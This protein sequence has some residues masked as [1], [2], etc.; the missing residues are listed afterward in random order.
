VPG[1]GAWAGFLSTVVPLVVTPGASLT[2]LVQRVTAD[3]RR[4]AVAVI[5]GTVTALAVYG[6]VVL[7]GMAFLVA[8]SG[9][10]GAVLRPAGA[11]YLVGLGCWMWRS[12]TTRP[13]DDVA[14]P[15]PSSRRSGYAQALLGTV[16]NPK[17]A[18]IY[19]TVVPRFVDPAGSRST[20]L[21]ALTAA[22]A[23]LTASWLAAWTAVLGPARRLTASGPWRARTTRASAVVLVALGV[24]WLVG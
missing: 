18:L 6:A 14:E 16:L 3:G 24:R 9:T 22:H 15:A 23:V 10:L 20:Q 5:G 8:P 13:V 19:L 12:A 1:G 7:A 17:A 4:Q 21:L 2:L 11:V